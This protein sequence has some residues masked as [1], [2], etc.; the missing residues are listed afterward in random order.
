MLEDLTASFS[1]PCILDLKVGTQQHSRDERP[2]KIASK[3]RKVSQ[4]TSA[5][6]GLRLCG[7]QVYRPAED[8]Y[9]FRDKYY[10]RKLSAEGLLTTLVEFV[11]RERAYVL[12]FFMRR[13]ESFL[14]LV[15]HQQHFLFRASSLLFV[16]EGRGGYV[17]LVDLDAQ[18]GDPAS[19]AFSRDARGRQLMDVRLIDFAHAD[20]AEGGEVDEGLCLGVRNLIAVF[21]AMLASYQRGE[22]PA[23]AQVELPAPAPHLPA[24]LAAHSTA[25]SSEQ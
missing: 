19:Q 13:L 22:E 17:N 20:A 25:S 21:R 8:S 12:P 9:L 24:A 5:S 16:Y 6:L 10:G 11:P 23:L 2:E 1:R 14:A 4:S 3:M 7:S 18:R 15:E